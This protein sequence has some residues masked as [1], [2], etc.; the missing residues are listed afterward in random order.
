M[1]RKY[2]ISKFLLLLLYL[3]STIFVNMFLFTSVLVH[4]AWTKQIKFVQK[5]STTV[6]NSETVYRT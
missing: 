1:R 6:K 5:P 3:F 2:R 4:E